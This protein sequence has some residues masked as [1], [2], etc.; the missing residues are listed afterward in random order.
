[1]VSRLLMFLTKGHAI[2]INE[3][4]SN[5]NFWGVDPLTRHPIVYTPAE[6]QAYAEGLSFVKSGYV[7]A[8]FTGISK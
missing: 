4:F 8:A 1:M 2:Y 7:S 5:G 3:Q 6:L